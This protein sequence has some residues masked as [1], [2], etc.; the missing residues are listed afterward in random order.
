MYKVTVDDLQKANH[1]EDGRKLQA[2]QIITIPMASQAASGSP[3]P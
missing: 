1:I 3:T 2:G